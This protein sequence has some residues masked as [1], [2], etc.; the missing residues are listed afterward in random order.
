MLVRSRAAPRLAASVP[1]ACDQTVHSCCAA[2][3]A[4]CSVHVPVFF[5]AA[6]KPAFKLDDL[7]D[8]IWQFDEELKQFGPNLKDLIHN[9]GKVCLH[10]TSVK[11]CCVGY[12]GLRLCSCYM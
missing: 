12:V 3:P 9:Q 10:E 7:E 11:C 4:C 2:C 6:L 1:Y 8:A 5:A